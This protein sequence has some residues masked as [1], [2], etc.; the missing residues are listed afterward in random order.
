MIDQSIL[1]PAESPSPYH[2]DMFKT[3]VLLRLFQRDG[4]PVYFVVQ[5]LGTLGDGESDLDDE[6]FYDE[7][8]CPTNYIPIEAVMTPEDDDPHGAFEYVRSVWMPHDYGQDGNERAKL[9]E[10]FPEMGQIAT[11]APCSPAIG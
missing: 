7:H 11:S 4:S 1:V 8:T 5:G 2:K 3:L 10:L 6:Y 9:R